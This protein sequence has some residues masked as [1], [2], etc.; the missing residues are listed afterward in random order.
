[1]LAGSP[2]QAAARTPISEA[3]SL[4]RMHTLSFAAADRDRGRIADGG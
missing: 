3:S 4:V 2:A 1:V